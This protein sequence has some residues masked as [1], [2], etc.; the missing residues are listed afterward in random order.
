MMAE[1]PGCM[2]CKDGSPFGEYG[3]TCV[4]CDIQQGY[5]RGREVERFTP[6]CQEMYINHCWTQ[7]MKDMGQMMFAFNDRCLDT[8]QMYPNMVQV[9]GEMR[10]ECMAGYHESWMDNCDPATM[11][12]FMG[13]NDCMDGASMTASGYCECDEPTFNMTMQGCRPV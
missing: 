5:T 2:M 10:C 13:C 12:C 8:C 4:E 3:Q 6:H 7:D 1:F 9:P 11:D